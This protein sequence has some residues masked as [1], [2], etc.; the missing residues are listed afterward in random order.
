MS[1]KI[2][3]YISLFF[4]LILNLIANL[5]IEN[6]FFVLEKCFN[7]S[8]YLPTKYHLLLS[9]IFAFI[10]ILIYI[11]LL[12]VVFKNQE[13]QKGINLKAE[14]GTYGT[15]NWLNI[16]E[17]SKILGLNDEPGILLGKKD[18]KDVLL[19]FD[20][21]FNKN[22]LVIGSSRQYEINWFYSSKYFTI[23]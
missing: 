18:G 14:D 15:A 12:L 7:R 10:S 1:K 17:A 2:I 22:I 3:K 20:S 8:I 11:S 13:V 21:F 19:P 9:I 23:S 6:Y 5:N 4:L 16:N